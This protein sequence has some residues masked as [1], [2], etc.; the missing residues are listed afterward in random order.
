MKL[1]STENQY[2]FSKILAKV[3]LT[4]FAFLLALIFT[5]VNKNF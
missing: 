1:Y 5:L 4:S 3:A 2:A